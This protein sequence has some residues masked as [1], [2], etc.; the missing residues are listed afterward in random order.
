MVRFVEVFPDEESFATLSQKL[1]WSRFIAQSNR[2]LQA[3]HCRKD[4]KPR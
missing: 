1:E 4:E 3:N 2:Q